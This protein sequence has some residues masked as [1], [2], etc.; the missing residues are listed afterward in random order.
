[1]SLSIGRKGWVGVGLQSAFQ[2]PVAIADYVPFETNTLHGVQEQLK[3]Q[4]AYGNREQ[5]FSSV[6][7]KRYAEGDF[8]MLLDSKMAGY[9]LVAGMGSVSVSALGG[10]V[11]QHTIT[12]NNSNTP[13]YLQLTSDRVVDRQNYF[14]TTVDEFSIEVGTDLAMLKTKLKGSFP[15]T[16]VSGTNTTTSGN[17]MSFKNAAFAFGASVSAATNAA[18]LKPHDFKLD[19]KNNVE[20]VHRHGSADAAVI[21]SKAFTVN[22]EMTLYFENTTDRD[23][24]Y[25]QSKQ[26]AVLQFNGAG[27]GGGFTEQLLVRLYQVSYE[28]FELETGLDN[29]YAEKAKLVGEY[30]N[31]NSK[32]VDMLLTNTKSLYI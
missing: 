16:T 28:G 5:V 6:A 10:G 7:G 17:V 13:Q 29:F 20:V 18:N 9:F 15:Q 14:D 2:T 11:Y 27:I 23:A 25:A 21:A 8:E 26:A 1:M 30:D 4:S 22:A 24:Y 19:I 31:S 3:V 32:S 12:R